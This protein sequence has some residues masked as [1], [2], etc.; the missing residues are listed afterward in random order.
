MDGKVNIFIRGI[1]KIYRTVTDYILQK[2][3]RNPDYTI[4]S[5]ICVGGSNM[6]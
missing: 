3:L 5:P 4:L 6:S 1:R 2:M